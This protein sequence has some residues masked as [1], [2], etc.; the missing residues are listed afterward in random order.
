V[1][2]L[3]GAPLAKTLGFQA[4]NHVHGNSPLPFIGN[5]NGTVRMRKVAS[6]E[7]QPC[8]TGIEFFGLL[9]CRPFFG[10]TQVPTG[11]NAGE[12]AMQCEEKAG[13]L[14]AWRTCV[15][16]LSTILKQAETAKEFSEY[17]VRVQA[18]ADECKLAYAKFT[19][20]LSEHG[21]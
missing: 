20:H 3:H 17:S 16:N 7:N 15:E 9:S 10:S 21:C 2:R 12:T 11:D 1:A 8:I 5:V 4:E 18:A 14:H 6:V 13:L 19:K